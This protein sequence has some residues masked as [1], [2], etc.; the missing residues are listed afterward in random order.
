MHYMGGYTYIYLKIYLG[1]EFL[2]TQRATARGRRV[3]PPHLENG[4]LQDIR[5]LSIDCTFTCPKP[6]L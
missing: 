3:A 1:S 5:A 6:S 4:V 2:G